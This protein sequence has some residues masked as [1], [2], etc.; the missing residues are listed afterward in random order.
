[1]KEQFRKRI[2]EVIL[3]PGRDPGSFSR[4]ALHAEVKQAVKHA[5]FSRKKY[6]I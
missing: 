6:G 2:V 4:E 3:P 5:G 1:L